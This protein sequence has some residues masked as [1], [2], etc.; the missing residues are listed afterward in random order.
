MMDFIIA[1][2]SGCLITAISVMVIQVVAMYNYVKKYG[3][4]RILHILKDNWVITV[5]LSLF[6]WIG[7]VFILA[8]VLGILVDYIKDK[9]KNL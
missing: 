3:K 6:S 2:L 5:G 8:T 7:M 1:Y 4:K 9:I